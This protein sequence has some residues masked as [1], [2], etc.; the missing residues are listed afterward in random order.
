MSNGPRPS[1]RWFRSDRE[2]LVEYNLAD[3]RLALEV[4]EHLGLIELSIERSRVTGMPIDR[5]SASVASFDFLY[6]SELGRRG[7]VA[8]SVG[9]PHGPD[10]ENF[11]PMAGGHL[12]APRTGLHENVL[13]ARLQ[14]P[15]P[16]PDAHV[17]DRPTRSTLEPATTSDRSRRRT[18]LSFAAS[19]ESSL[20]CSTICCRVVT[21]PD[22][23]ATLR[24]RRRS[25]S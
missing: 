9:D 1:S 13:A 7:I 5:V 2:R 14:E 19:L 3:A 22:A 16:E 15:V 8:P 10:R 24:P 6:L 17:S 4:I 25:R 11:A 12:L 21:P 20:G 18:A 23:P